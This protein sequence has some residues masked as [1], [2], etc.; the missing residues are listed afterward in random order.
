MKFNLGLTIKVMPLTTILW[1][2][3]MKVALV[4]MESWLSQITLVLLFPSPSM[5]IYGLS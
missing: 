1:A 2:W 4:A 3:E 5:Y